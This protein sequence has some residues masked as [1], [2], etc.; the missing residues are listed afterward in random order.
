MSGGSSK[1][2]VKSSL[3]T[4]PEVRA[5]EKAGPVGFLYTTLPMDSSQV[6]QALSPETDGL[7]GR[8][9]PGK[10]VG[11]S[12]VKSDQRQVQTAGGPTA[13]KTGASEEEVKPPRPWGP[14]PATVGP[15]GPCTPLPQPIQDMLTCAVPPT[16]DPLYLTASTWTMDLG[17]G[18]HLLGGFC[19]AWQARSLMG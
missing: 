4:A 2:A 8:K 5:P 11:L 3:L 1:G 12:C 19:H 17:G 13:Q 9:C 7:P 18:C 14:M 10:A 6:D 16:P 15:G